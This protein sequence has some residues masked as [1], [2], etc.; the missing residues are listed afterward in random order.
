MLQITVA[1]VMRIAPADRK[2]F[3]HRFVR[4]AYEMRGAAEKEKIKTEQ[5]LDLSLSLRKSRN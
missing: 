1:V 2:L 4:I 5:S 3:M